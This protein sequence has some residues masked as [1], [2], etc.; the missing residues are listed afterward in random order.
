LE[1]NNFKDGYK[2]IK[3][4]DI[5]RLL[6]YCETP[7]TLIEQVVHNLSFHR[8]LGQDIDI[9]LYAKIGYDISMDF[10]MEDSSL[11]S[12]VKRMVIRDLNSADFLASDSILQFLRGLKNSQYSLIDQIKR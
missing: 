11:N 9:A 3:K 2:T 5:L 6:Q 1:N 8:D 12:K 4:N 7:S 10:K